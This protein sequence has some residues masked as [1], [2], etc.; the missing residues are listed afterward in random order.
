MKTLVRKAALLFSAMLLAL[1]ALPAAALADDGAG[2]AKVEEPTVTKTVDGADSATAAAGDSVEFALVSQ[3]PADLWECLDFNIGEVSTQSERSMGSVISGASYTLT[4]HDTMDPKLV[5]D[6]GSMRVFIG[7]TELSSTQY[8]YSSQTGDDCTFH[9]ALDLLDLYTQGAIVDADYEGNTSITVK[10]DAALSNDAVAGAY[11]NTVYVG[12]EKSLFEREDPTDP[13]PDAPSKD[14]GTS[15]SD[16]VT[17]DTFAINLMKIDNA[18]SSPLEGATFRLEKSTG[19]GWEQIGELKTTDA[20]GLVSWDGLDVGSYRLTETQAP[21]GY[22]L[23]DTPVEVEIPEEAGASNTATVTFSN[24]QTP[25]TGGAGTAAYAGG[26]LAILAC[27][28]VLF[29]IARKRAR[30]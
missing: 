26:G 18:D 15:E 5:M 8:Q 17:V 24:G 2:N 21:S 12:W 27:A 23:I 22:V 30:R 16:E 4:F 28:A 13:V 3:V 29:A 6:P 20:E 7:D 11:K 14:S 10:Y 9:V 25:T 1:A 19:A